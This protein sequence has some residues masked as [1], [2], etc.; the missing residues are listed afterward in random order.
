MMCCIWQSADRMTLVDQIM[1]NGLSLASPRVN[2]ISERLFLGRKKTSRFWKCPQFGNAILLYFCITV[3]WSFSSAFRCIQM[4]GFSLWTSFSFVCD[5][6]FEHRSHP[7]IF[8]RSTGSITMLSPNAINYVFGISKQSVRSV[9]LFNKISPWFWIFSWVQCSF[10]FK[11]RNLFAMAVSVKYAWILTEFVG[12]G[13]QKLTFCCS[14][15]NF[16]SSELGYLGRSRSHSGISL[17]TAAS[18]R[19]MYLICSGVK[20]AWSAIVYC[21]WECT[22]INLYLS[23]LVVLLPNRVESYWK[24]VDYFLL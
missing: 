6:Y 4:W 15:F 5:F 7:N 11:T 13:N 12:V 3:N 24:Q 14:G 1:L 18:T 10:C 20:W 9:K 19:L 17:S 16:L 23:Y 8:S 21:S 22:V 2:P